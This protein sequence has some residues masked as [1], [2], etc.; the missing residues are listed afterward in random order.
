MTANEL[1]CETSGVVPEEKRR[2]NSCDKKGK[3][4]TDTST[5]RKLWLHA[6]ERSHI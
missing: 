5:V 1:R 2:R 3:C 4:Y 6:A